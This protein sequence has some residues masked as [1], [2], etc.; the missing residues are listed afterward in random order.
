MLMKLIEV[1]HKSFIKV[2]CFLLNKKYISPIHMP[3]IIKQF[4]EARIPS[5]GGSDWASWASLPQSSS[6]SQSSKGIPA[7]TAILNQ[8]SSIAILLCRRAS[9]RGS[10][11]NN[12]V[13]IQHNLLI[14]YDQTVVSSTHQS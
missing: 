10:I 11:I 9:A 13:M 14:I 12:T 5:E 7:S 6:S 2:Y 1:Q 3:H 4:V 8:C